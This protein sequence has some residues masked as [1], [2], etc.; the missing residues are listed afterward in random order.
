MANLG[1][2]NIAYLG[3]PLALVDPAST[4]VGTCDISFF[5]GPALLSTEATGV[6]VS[7]TCDALTLTEYGATV[8]IDAVVTATCDALTLTEN[9]ANIN[10]EI[11]FTA[12]VDNLTLTA[13][14][15]TVTVGVSV[16]CTSVSATLLTYDAA[17]KVDTGVIANVQA[18]TLTSYAA[19][20]SEDIDISA[21]VVSLTLS[22]KSASVKLNVDVSTILDTLTLTE[23]GATVSLD[24]G[25]AATCDTLTLTTK[26]APVE[27]DS[28]AVIE[29]GWSKDRGLGP[30][31]FNKPPKKYGYVNNPRFVN[32]SQATDIHKPCGYWPLVYSTVGYSQQCIDIYDDEK[33]MACAAIDGD[34][35]K[36]WFLNFETDELIKEFNIY[37]SNSVNGFYGA[38]TITKTP[39]DEFRAIYI[40]Y[41]GSDL[42]AYVWDYSSSPHKIVLETDT[43][44]YLT[45]IA[46]LQNGIIVAKDN[47][48]DKVHTSLDYG[49]TWTTYSSAYGYPLLNDRNGRLYCI[50]SYL[51]DDLPFRAYYSDNYGETWVEIDHGLDDTYGDGSAGVYPS[52]DGDVIYLVKYVDMYDP[53]TYIF[54]SLNKGLTW[55]VK[56]APTVGGFG[57]VSYTVVAGIKDGVFILEGQLNDDPDYTPVYL[58]STDYGTAWSA[59]KLPPYEVVPTLEK[60]AYWQLS[61]IGD[62]WL[63]TFCGL[64]ISPGDLSFMVSIDDS[65]TWMNRSLHI[66]AFSVNYGPNPV[67][68]LPGEN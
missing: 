56:A 19:T 66:G 4:D 38:I 28:H 46:N 40:N 61:I 9:A 51:G 68:K 12:G 42:C 64:Y 3:G 41:D 39:D 57:I 37:P 18:L 67:W 6:E 58:R 15:A 55:N 17:V 23:R 31:E 8:V 24:I 21:G 11:S 52:V 35:Y 10:A 30:W 16:N 47:L 54:Y 33:I 43:S 13:S 48:S 5:G 26:F 62:Y 20:L 60:T 44:S 14:N 34:H 1:E 63:R 27:W 49:T 59:Y 32:K 65:L 25:I 45:S 29:T 7:A 53:I 2:S 22:E 50:G 36:M